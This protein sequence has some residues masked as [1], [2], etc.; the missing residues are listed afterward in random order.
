MKNPSMGVDVHCDYFVV[1]DEEVGIDV[2]V[3]AELVV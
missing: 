1:G 2:D 3:R